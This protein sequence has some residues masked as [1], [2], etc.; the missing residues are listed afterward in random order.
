MTL[1]KYIKK[2]KTSN[3]WLKVD[4]DCQQVLKEN[5]KS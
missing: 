3:L 2:F 1:S 4:N 5:L